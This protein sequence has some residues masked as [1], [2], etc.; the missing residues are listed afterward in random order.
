MGRVTA[1]F[2]V[3]GW[4]R[5]EPFSATP[6]SLCAYRRWWLGR[7]KQWRTVAVRDARLH[8]KSLVALLEGVPDRDA[9][10]AFTGF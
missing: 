1:P 3:G 2:G 10:A 6:G 8:G 4:I 9:A 7:G 5:V